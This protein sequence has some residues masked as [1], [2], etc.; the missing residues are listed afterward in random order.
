MQQNDLPANPPHADESWRTIEDDRWHLENAT[1]DR[2]AVTNISL[3]ENPN[4]G[5]EVPINA[6][7]EH[8]AGAVL[9][10][11][12]LDPWGHQPGPTLL[13]AHRVRAEG[14]TFEDPKYVVPTENG[15]ISYVDAADVDQTDSYLESA[16]HPG[17]YPH[18]VET[19]PGA[20]RCLC[21]AALR[22]SRRVQT[23]K[24]QADAISDYESGQASL[25][26]WTPTA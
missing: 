10:C 26:S 6:T 8:E 2:W 16:G 4:H 25:K 13:R 9:N 1:S 3:V 24:E 23:L 15:G 14:P 20:K 18:T 21:A 22:V 17:G 5:G 11:S 12:A 19:V 7:L